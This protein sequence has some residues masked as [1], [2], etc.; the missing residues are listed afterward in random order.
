MN[1]KKST[2]SNAMSFAW[3]L[4]LMIW[5]VR[6]NLSAKKQSQT[7]SGLQHLWLPRPHSPQ[8][9][10]SFQFASTILLC[11]GWRQSLEDYQL[12]W[13]RLMGWKSSL[14]VGEREIDPSIRI[15]EQRLTACYVWRASFFW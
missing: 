4:I 6:L 12:I 8:T 13:R 15:V 2:S 14:P 11:G 9:F 5:Q 3:A 10:V 1:D 7:M